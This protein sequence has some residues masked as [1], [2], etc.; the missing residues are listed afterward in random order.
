VLIDELIN[1]IWTRTQQNI[2]FMYMLRKN[3]Q[4][5]KKTEIGLMKMRSK[6]SYLKVQ[7]ICLL[8][9]ICHNLF[10]SMFVFGHV[11]YIES[12]QDIFNWNV[13]EKCI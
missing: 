10:E 13:N 1:S 11:S 2:F 5:N 3:H 4:S 7:A 6:S 8:K 12:L 9:L